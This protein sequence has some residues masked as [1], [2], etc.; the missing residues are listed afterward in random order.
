MKREF[1]FIA[2]WQCEWYSREFLLR[3]DVLDTLFSIDLEYK[4][5]DCYKTGP[6][7]TEGGKG[8]FGLEFQ[9]Q[10]IIG[11]RQETEQEQKQE[12]MEESCLVGFGGLLSYL[13]LTPV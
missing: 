7:A 6:D 13:P 5:S 2:V 9:S 11:G 4:L 3:D 10:P 12:N 1:V 8:V